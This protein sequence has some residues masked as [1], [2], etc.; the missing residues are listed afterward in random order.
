MAFALGPRAE[1]AGCRI[2]SFETIGSTNAEALARARAGDDGPLWIVSSEQ[3][4]GRGRRGRAWATTG[5]NLAASLLLRC[6]V[7]PGLAATLGFVAA[8]SLE[9]ALQSC[10]PGL[11]VTL[12][13]PN[14]VLAEGS[15]LAGI[16]LESERAG[17]ALRIVVGIGVNVASSPSDTAFPAVSLSDL[18]RAVRAQDLFGTLSDAWIDV[19]RIWEGGAG[20]PRIRTLWLAKAAGVGQPVRVSLD[21]RTIEG[22]FETLDEQGRLIVRGADGRLTPV[23]AGDVHFG[24]ARTAARAEFR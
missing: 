3:T 4:K 11:A 19:H 16:L 17:D 1:R 5:G 18:G 7:P 9:E 12:K 8:L 22:V 24:T 21:E 20:M 13:W 15:K 6:D 23:S 10:A 2:A 14:D